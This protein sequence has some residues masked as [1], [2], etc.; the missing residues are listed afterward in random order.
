MLSEV[1]FTAAVPE[2]STWIM[3][4]LGFAGLGF[5]MYRRNARRVPAVA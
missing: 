5:G 4:L 1:E 3:M 2:P